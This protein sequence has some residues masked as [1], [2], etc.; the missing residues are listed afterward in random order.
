MAERIATHCVRDTQGRI[1]AIGNPAEDWHRHA[2]WAIQDIV[3]DRHSYR[4][5]GP[6]GD[7]ANIHVVNGPSGPYLRSQGDTSAANNLDDLPNFQPGAWEIALEDTEILAIHAALVPHGAEGQVLMFGGDEHDPS[8]AD[9]NEIF[10]TRIYDVERNIVIDIDSPEVDVF[11]C[12]HAFLGDG[13]LFVAGGTEFWRHGAD[14]ENP[15]PADHFDMH[16]RPRD[17]WSGARE[18]AAYDLDGTWSA[19]ADMLPEPD[20]EP[21]TGGGRWYPTLLTLPDGRILAV[22]G[23][24]SL[25]DTRHG[26]W[27][28]E[29]YDSNTDSWEYVGGHWIYVD[30][31]D[32]PV[33][34]ELEEHDIDGQT[35]ELP[36]GDP[37]LDDDGQLIELREFPEGQTRPTSNPDASF[38]YLY[39]PRLYVVPEGLVFMV[40]PNDGTSR[41]YDPSTGQPVGHEIGQP[42]H[43]SLFAETNHTAVLLPLL[44]G[45]DYRPHVVLLGNEGPHRVSLG[46]HDSMDD[47]PA[48]EPTADR[49]WNVTPPLRRHGCATILP[50]GAV[51]FSGGI[52]Q[53][54]DAPLDDDN[55]ALN[56]EMYFPGIDWEADRIDFAT[57]RW[58]TIEEASVPRNYHSV[59]LLL[60][61]GRVLT[62]G[63]NK[64]GQSGGD[65][66]KEYRVEVFTPIYFY[67]SRR[68]V[69][70]ASPSQ[71]SYGEDFT[72]ETA[73]S[74][75]IERAALFRCGSMTHAWDGDQR[76]VGLEFEKIDGGL[77]LTAPPNG[78]VAPPGPYMLWIVATEDLPCKLAPF[79]I[80]S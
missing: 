20:R 42:D 55:A 28:P 29:I 67:D 37:I 72:I 1:Q 49:Q 60:P 43:G 18:A 31:A 48:W 80:L 78:N 19:L 22:G 65:N 39:Y 8:N 79:V 50:T 73:Q 58:S 46:A 41:W 15:D 44:P 13:R 74:R 76:Y 71:I 2:P 5:E 30:W 10:N 62:G 61:N 51:L 4:T 25:A 77:R 24:P 75:R 56:G 7:R 36:T 21:P 53:A 27:M 38:N 35:V 69:I 34:R 26:A 66:V 52:D 32:M 6:D 59:A 14:F 3:S 64:N 54:G 23:H 40:S 12:G 63:S 47:V 33:E 45:D 57:E 16:Q 11:C 17:H 68:P 70:D 9:N